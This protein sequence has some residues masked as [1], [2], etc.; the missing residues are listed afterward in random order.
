MDDIIDGI[1]ILSPF[2]FW[3]IIFIVRDYF[4][5]KE[6]ERDR[7]ERK[8]SAIDAAKFI[9]GQMISSRYEAANA[10]SWVL[11]YFH[12]IHLESI[13]VFYLNETNTCVEAVV[14]FGNEQSVNFPTE[15]ICSMAQT[16]GASKLVIAHNHPRNR[17]TPSDNDIYFAVDLLQNACMYNLEILDN[18][19]WCNNGLKSIHNTLRFKQMIRDY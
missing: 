2:I 8:K 12:N 6:K 17:S 14:R 1:I 13:V 15:E 9:E 16:K 11:K 3:F 19:V 10:V 7:E 4:R 18:L 5:A